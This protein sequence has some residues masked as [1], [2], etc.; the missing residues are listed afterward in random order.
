M[1]GKE[2]V[3]PMQRAFRSTLALCA[4]VLHPCAA[5]AS[6]DQTKARLCDS[7][8]RQAADTTGVPLDVMLAITRVETGRSIAGVLSPWPWAVNQAGDG[9]FFETA[10]QAM[11]HVQQAMADGATNIDIGCFQLNL[12]WHGDAF[13]SLNAMFEPTENAD[14]AAQFLLQLH[15]EFG[16]W[17]GAIGAY[18][19]RNADA[20]EGYL[21]KVAALMAD[22]PPEG[23]A[24]VASAENRYPLLRPGAPAGL[25]SLV[26]SSFDTPPLPLLR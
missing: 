1:A 25:G 2:R 11:D 14:Y 10:D 15:D 12:R 26:S 5:L 6:A 7:A 3:K 19:S 4:A 21:A 22:A 23:D 8:A 13:T 9:T 20:A 17:E 24:P 18:H 16:S